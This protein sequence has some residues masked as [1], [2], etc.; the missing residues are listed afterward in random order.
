MGACQSD[1]AHADWETD[2]LLDDEQ[3]LGQVANA[4][5]TTFGRHLQ[6]FMLPQKRSLQ[7]ALRVPPTIEAVAREAREGRTPSFEEIDETNRLYAMGRSQ[8]NE[9]SSLLTADQAA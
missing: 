5:E 6:A 8:M 9:Y 1:G 2:E 7:S 3:V 4:G